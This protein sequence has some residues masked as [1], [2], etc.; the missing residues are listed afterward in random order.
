MNQRVGGLVCEEFG[1]SGG[2]ED[3]IFSSFS[4]RFQKNSCAAI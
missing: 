3:H 4:F 1:F 2:D